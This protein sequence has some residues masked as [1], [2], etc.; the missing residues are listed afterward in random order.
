MSIWDSF[1]SS[2]GAFFRKG[3]FRC[4]RGRAPRVIGPRR[5]LDSGVLNMVL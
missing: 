3:P 4:V 5:F 1:A 2:F